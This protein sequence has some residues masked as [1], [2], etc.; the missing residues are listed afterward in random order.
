MSQNHRYYRGFSLIEIMIVIAIIGII[1]G[2]AMPSYREHVRKGNR[3]DGQ[4]ALL[5]MASTMETYF[6]TNKTYSA[7][8]TD[9][10]YNS[11]SSDGHYTL[12]ISSA[13]TA[14]PITSCY[15]LKA[16]AV[17]GQASDGDLTINSF[18]QKLPANKW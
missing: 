5:N 11:A 8:L 17:G 4:A 16:T 13:T 10:G 14:C 7:S 9:I 12:S 3:S 15:E 18:G 1:A 2:I 6:Y